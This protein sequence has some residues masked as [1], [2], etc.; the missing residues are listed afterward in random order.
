M[1]DEGVA[2]GVEEPQPA[3]VGAVA[4]GLG[5]DVGDGPVVHRRGPPAEP[6]A[7]PPVRVALV[8]TAPEPLHGVHAGPEAQAHADPRDVVEAVGH[9]DRVGDQLPAAVGRDHLG[10]QLDQ[11]RPRRGGPWRSHRSACFWPTV[12]PEGLV[13]DRRPPQR[14]RRLQVGQ[15][16]GACRGRAHG[17]PAGPGL[18][19]SSTWSQAT[20]WPAGAQGRSWRVRKVRVSWAAWPG[21]RSAPRAPAPG[22]R[23]EAPA[24]RSSGSRRPEPTTSPSTSTCP[25]G[26]QPGQVDEVVLV[27][28]LRARPGPRRR[29]R[30][31]PAPPPGPA[32]AATGAGCGRP[33]PGRCSRRGRRWARRRSRRRRPGAR[34]RRRASAPGPGRP[35]PR[36][37]RPA[38]RGGC[39]WR[40]SSRPAPPQELPM[41]WMYSHMISGRSGGGAGGPG[42]D[43]VDRRVHGGDHVGLGRRP[44][45]ELAHV[46]EGAPGD[47]GEQVER[48]C[49]P[50]SAPGARGRRPGATRPRPAGSGAEPL[51][52]PSDHMTTDGW[53]LSRWAMR[54]MRSRMAPRPGRVAG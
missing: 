31:A 28:H 40:P 43:V 44:G 15:G 51:S 1:H 41:A 7:L 47:V 35:S 34:C 46:G 32:P 23:P 24:A 52:L 13:V 5:V 45:Q 8:G 14:E 12:G 18:R 3:H 48:R 33:R 53:A 10:R 19:A 42:D 2:G 25:R 50:R 54:T 4:A 26:H 38:G 27:V 20:T 37:T 11:R 16:A 21:S 17:R 9:H 39:G 36:R 6:G 30:R 29:R 49:R 22:P